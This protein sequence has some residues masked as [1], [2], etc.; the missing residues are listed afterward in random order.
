MDEYKVRD[1]PDLIKRGGGVINTNQDEY[2]RAKAR[3]MQAQR[4]DNLEGEV[5]GLHSK[6]D[7]LVELLQNAKPQ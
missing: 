7:L 3:L 5:R 6:L 4:I 1:F 2:H